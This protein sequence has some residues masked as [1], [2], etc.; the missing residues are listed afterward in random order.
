MIRIS[1]ATLIFLSLSL[2]LAASVS[3]QSNGSQSG[4]MSSAAK[5]AQNSK[6]VGPTATTPSSDDPD[7]NSTP[8][9]S[10][11]QI[12]SVARENA[13]R[14]Y[15]AGMKYGRANLFR[16]A[17]QSFQQAVEND[18]EFADAYYGLGMAHSDLGEY[19]QAVA[20]FQKALKLNPQM[21]DAYTALGQAYSKLNEKKEPAPT[22]SRPKGEPL[23]QPVDSN[24][25]PANK[26]EEENTADADDPTRIYRVG[27]GDVLDIRIRGV[28]GNASTLFTVS[29]DGSLSHPLFSHALSVVGLTTD[30]IGER[31]SGE[32]KQRSMG[33]DGITQVAVREYNSHVVLISGLVKEPG[34]K[35]LRREAIPL[36]V[37]LADAQPLPE[38]ALAN[39]VSRG[40]QSRTVDLAE[41]EQMSLLVKPGD[42]ITI[43]P[44]PKQFFYVGGEVKSPGELPFRPGLTLTQAIISAGGIKLKGDKVQLTRGRGNGLLTMREFKLKDINKG[45]IPDPLVEAGDRITV[46]P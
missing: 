24:S 27:A 46:L 28:S 1:G 19:S 38:A 36:Y 17:L 7:V 26:N 23:G 12:D 22:K 35:I 5:T 13:R 29:E 25:D 45:K 14:Q 18:P 8:E 10:K 16:Q 3:A 20:A 15:K 34:T 37:V 44:A 2:T 6:G 32:L 40:A 33:D 39:V 4:S 21:V 9:K 43:Q 11:K 41:A 31:V 42:V 30:Q